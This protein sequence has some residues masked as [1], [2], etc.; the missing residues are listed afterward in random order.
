[1]QI[2]KPVRV[3]HTYNQRFC[4]K[5]EEVF[6]LL[7]PVR[8]SEWVEGW[9]P[10]VVFSESGYAEPDCVFVTED[11]AG[12]SVWVIT[13]RDP[14]RFLLEMVKVTPGMTV[15]RIEIR[16]KESGAD[17]TEAT[18]TYRYTALAEQGIQFVHEYTEE[19]FVHFMEYWEKTLNEFLLSRA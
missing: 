14:S 8:E 1:M 9:D 18:V 17:E 13:V 12:Q 16:L 5:P 6:P 15:A 3:E 7:C 10:L 19:L 4:A 2:I 11:Q